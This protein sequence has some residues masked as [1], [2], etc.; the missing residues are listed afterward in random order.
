[1]RTLSIET[2]THGRVLVE[3]ARAL[4]LGTIVVFHGYGQSADDVLA[5]ATRIPDVSRWTIVAVQGLHRFYTRSDDKVI[6][7]WMTR[8]DR[9]EAIADNIAYVD[10]VVGSLA[11]VGALVYMGFSQGVAMAYRAA[12]L[13]TRRADGI[14]ALAGDIPPELKTGAPS[15][16]WPPVLI[17]VGDKDTWYTPEKV[18]GDLTFLAAHEVPHDLLRFNG[19]HVWTGEFRE[20]SSRWLQRLSQA[21]AR[22]ST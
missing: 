12:L 14:I 7:S 4:A 2:T 1:M 16:R 22:S 19:G 15:E 3:D 9:D 18:D 20:A 6:A 10:R 11:P 17:G 21:A 5:E 13:G 8:Q